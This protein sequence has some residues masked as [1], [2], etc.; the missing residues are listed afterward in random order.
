MSEQ[1]S[2]ELTAYLI[3]RYEDLE[4]PIVSASPQREWMSFAEG[5]A[6][7][8]LPLTMA[9]QMGWFL[10][11]PAGFVAEWEG[12]DSTA[13]IRIEFDRELV[14][15]QGEFVSNLFGNGILSWKLPYL[16]RTAPGYNLL[17]RGPVNHIKDGVQ[18]LEGM[19]ES[20]WI[21]ATFTMNWKITRSHHPVRFEQ[22]E[23]F[24]MITPVRRG[25]VERFEPKVEPIEGNAPLNE[26]Y[27]LW[28]K[29]RHDAKLRVQLGYA[30][31][32]PELLKYDLNYTRGQTASG[33]TLIADHQTRLN[34]RAFDPVWQKQYVRLSKPAPQNEP[35][36][37]SQDEG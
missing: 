4:I 6:Y 20:D 37:N 11:N 27:L 12:D 17:A 33:Q 36:P 5:N 32:R 9:N 21:D 24:C 10:L 7:R 14:G 18:A 35:A 25:D 13:P 28:K 29:K 15:K 23:P 22:G 1:D 3:C 26:A 34:V 31:Q 30:M 16:F 2:L 19:V 8:C